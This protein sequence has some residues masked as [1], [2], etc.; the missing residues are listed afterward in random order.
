[1]KVLYGKQ[2]ARAIKLDVIRFEMS[3]FL[4]EIKKVSTWTVFENKTAN[5]VTSVAFG[6]KMVVNTR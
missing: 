2:N 1:M 4:Y 6:Y 5:F 3:S